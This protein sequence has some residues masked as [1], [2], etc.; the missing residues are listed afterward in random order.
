[1]RVSACVRACVR[2]GGAQEQSGHLIPAQGA[3]WRGEVEAI[4]TPRPVT[5]GSSHMPPSGSA[6]FSSLLTPHGPTCLPQAPDSKTPLRSLM[7]STTCDERYRC[8]RSGR[9]VGCA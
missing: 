2:A 5:L 4:A 8:S 6:A 7:P 1:M 9:G 3:V